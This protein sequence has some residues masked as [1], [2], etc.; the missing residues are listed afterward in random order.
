MG[1]WKRS[2]G[3]YL[4][5]GSGGIYMEGKITGK[6]GVIAAVLLATL[7]GGA[8]QA[9]AWWDAKWQFRKKVAFDTTA[10]GADLK[11]NITEVPVLLRL[12]T[13]NFS[14]PNA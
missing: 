6:Y 7:L 14:F 2:A 5:S 4:Y 10:K 9:E 1:R 3:N 12:H 8:L 11:E 13:A